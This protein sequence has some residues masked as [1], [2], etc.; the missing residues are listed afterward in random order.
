MQSV[1]LIGANG[2]LGTDLR[3][4]FKSD[5]DI[6]LALT[7][8][9]VDIRDRSLIAD[10]LRRNQ[11]DV[12]VN[13]AAFHKVEACELDVDQAF[14]V[15]CV[16]VRNLALEAQAVGACLVH[17]STDYVFGGDYSHP[18]FTEDSPVAPVNA[19]GASKAAGEF[20]VRSLCQRHLVVRTSGLYGAA[21]S[22]GKGGNFVRTM[23]RAGR[24]QGVV[25]VVTDQILSPTNTRDLA[26]M[27]WRL[28][29]SKAGGLFHVTNSGSC[30]W[31]DFARAIFELSGI[32]VDVRP[33]TT[34]DSGAA[35]RR[36]GYSVLTNRRLELEGLEL[37]RPWELALTSH[38]E[39]IGEALRPPL[40]TSG[41]IQS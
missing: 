1:I 4:E 9:Q 27:I 17:L 10:V 2:Q 5:G 29:D 22:S 41:V 38:L 15:N 35:V 32:K 7:H 39:E 31:F 18:P 34:S 40:T 36:P 13:T 23:L 8:E 20:F 21:G 3:R 24:Q 6:L 37:M 30:S 14:A 28:V 16:G 33:I 26:R 25:S 12:V 11:P 19:Y